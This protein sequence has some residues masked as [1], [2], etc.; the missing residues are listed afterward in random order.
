MGD[1]E[2]HGETESLAGGDENE[3]LVILDPSHVNSMLLIIII[4]LSIKL[5]SFPACNS[6]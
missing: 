3:E 1:G 5:C 4:L 6:L 2:E